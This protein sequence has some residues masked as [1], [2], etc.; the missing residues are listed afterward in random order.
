MNRPLYSCILNPLQIFWMTSCLTLVQKV[1]DYLRPD[2]AQQAKKLPRAVL[3]CPQCEAH[4]IPKQVPKPHA[5]GRQESKRP[6]G[7]LIAL[8]GA[9]R[10]RT[11]SHP[12]WA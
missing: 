10:R 8:V 4:R 9:A 11:H 2:T 5:L 12:L 1:W 6:R 3:T 7:E